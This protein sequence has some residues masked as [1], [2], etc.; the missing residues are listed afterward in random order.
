MPPTSS[1]SRMSAQRTTPVESRHQRVRSSAFAKS[2]MVH[3]NLL[4]CFEHSQHYSDPSQKELQIWEVLSQPHEAL[5]R[6]PRDRETEF[7]RNF[8]K[9]ETAYRVRL[10]CLIRLGSN[11]TRLKSSGIPSASALVVTNDKCTQNPLM[12]D[13]LL[14]LTST[15]PGSE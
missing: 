13:A 14:P 1:R 15:A 4:V 8:S 7:E 6:F 3:W 11:H 5:L 10:T 12:F 2:L 9:D